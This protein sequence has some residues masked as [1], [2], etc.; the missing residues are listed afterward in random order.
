MPDTDRR[1]FDPRFSRTDDGL[2]AGSL[3]DM[4]SIASDDLD[5]EETT[6]E[7]EHTGDHAVDRKPRAQ[8]LVIEIIFLAAHL[9][10]PVTKFPR[11]QRTE[12]IAGLGGAVLF[13]L[14]AFG[15]EFRADA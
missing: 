14:D 5:A 6:E 7:A 4:I 8:G 13:E 11:V 1:A 12:R 2:C 15:L 3:V 9:L 10:G